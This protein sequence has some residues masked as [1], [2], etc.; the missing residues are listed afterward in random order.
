MPTL[1]KYKGFVEIYLWDQKVAVA[2]WNKAGYAHFEYTPEFIATGLPLSP[3]RMPLATSG[4]SFPDLRRS[5]DF[6]GLP[7]LLADALP[8]KWGNTLIERWLVDQGREFATTDPIEKLCFI[9]NRTMGALEFKPSAGPKAKKVRLHVNELVDLAQKILTIKTGRVARLSAKGKD[10]LAQVIFVGSSVGGNRAKALIAWDRKTDEVRAGDIPQTK[11]FESW[12]IKFDETGSGDGA[13]P[14]GYGRIEYAYYLMAKAAGIDMMESRL[15]EEQ[16]RAHFMTQRFDRLN[17]GKKLHYQSLG[18]LAHLDRHQGPHRYEDA[19][20]VLRELKVPASANAE[21]FRRAVFNVAARNQ[22]DHVKNFGF[23][24]D[25]TGR[26]RLSPA[27]D[28]TWAFDP[29]G[30]WTQSHQLSIGGKTRALTRKDLLDL[31][32]RESVRQA[33][34]IVDQVCAAVDRWSEFAAQAKVPKPRA[35]TI[36]SYLSQA[37]LRK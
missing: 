25:E 16:G 37:A 35:D 29:G 2:S 22:D 8:D 17:G 28:V 13:Q 24:M 15:W 21:L 4:Y 6:Q 10:A 27:F 23:L 3:L 9:A 18:A 14:K 20:R 26:W 32:Q 1:S 36:K 19:F 31:A 34:R 5:E 11:A 33:D 7:G 12:I 30:T